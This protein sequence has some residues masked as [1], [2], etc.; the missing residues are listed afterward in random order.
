MS[1]ARTGVLMTIVAASFGQT[2]GPLS[3]GMAPRPP[4]EISEE[5]GLVFHLSEGTEAPGQRAV[6]AD[7]S[8]LDDAATQR[9]LDRLPLLAPA[10]GLQ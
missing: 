4:V 10:A 7:A 5:K 6:P 3:R 2:S 9:V 8:P 1:L